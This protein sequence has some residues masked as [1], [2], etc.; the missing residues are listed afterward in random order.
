MLHSP[1][2]SYVDMETG[3]TVL[4]LASGACWA[5]SRSDEGANRHVNILLVAAGSALALAILY[6]G[7]DMRIARI[8]AAAS[9]ALALV[10]L[11]W[12]LMSIAGPA[13]RALPPRRSVI[14][15]HEGGRLPA[16]TPRIGPEVRL[17]AEV[18]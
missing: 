17:P 12:V 2:L 6:V 3:L 11:E 15:D 10:G 5:W 13:A 9:V 4:V 18:L 8:S 7:G 16:W 14:G 1:L